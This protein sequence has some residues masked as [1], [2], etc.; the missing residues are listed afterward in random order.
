MRRTVLTA[1]A[2]FALS[3]VL[4]A[5]RLDAPRGY[6][7]D[8]FFYVPAARAFADWSAN[9]NR[10]NPPLAKYFI[11]LSIRLLGDTPA[12]WRAASTVFGALTVVAIY[13][14]GLTLFRRAQSPAIFAA[15]IALTNQHLYILARAAMLDVFMFCFMAWGMTAFCA[16]WMGDTSLRR[17]R[18]LLIFSGTMFGFATACKWLGVV[19]LGAA[20]VTVFAARARSQANKNDDARPPSAGQLDEVW[21]SP[22]PIRRLGW[23]TLLAAFVV[24]PFVAYCLTI[25][26]LL[27]LPGASLQQVISHQLYIWTQHTTFHG[28]PIQTGAWWAFPVSIAP[29]T[30]YF[31]RTP[32]TARTVVLLGN[33][34]VLWSGLAAVVWCGWEW[35]RRGSRP[36]FLIVLWYAALYFCWAV[37]P[38]NFF[39]RYYYFPA[40]T[41]LSLALAYFPYR[42]P[43]ARLFGVPAHWL[44]LTAA[45]IVFLLLLPL[46]SALPIP[47]ERLPF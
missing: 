32:E 1:L 21:Y 45:A 19:A 7:L 25:L 29:L 34:L 10:Y 36:A 41:I 4:F 31:E 16:A 39:Y 27:F 15:L 12:R 8:E 18:A 37:I 46:S 20:A 26:P 2:L 5:I 14:W 44:F 6:A 30:F 23:S 43:D 28:A 9:L 3:L 13:L 42:H 24:A 11:A 22:E 35:L 33:P 47:L 38:L 40:A 17:T